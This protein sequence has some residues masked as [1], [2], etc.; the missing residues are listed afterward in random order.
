MKPPSDA[1]VNERSVG[2]PQYTRKFDRNQPFAPGP[3][4]EMR[5]KACG[6][7][8]R[9]VDVSVERREPVG[10]RAAGNRRTQATPP[11]VCCRMFTLCQYRGLRRNALYRLETM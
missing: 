7:V 4:Q 11:A 6:Q 9:P 2:L 1:C 3:A 5:A 8:S 10:A